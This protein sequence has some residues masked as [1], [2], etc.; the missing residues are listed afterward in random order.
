MPHFPTMTVEAIFDLVCS[1][2]LL[3]ITRVFIN[4][5]NQQVAVLVVV[6]LGGFKACFI[7]ADFFAGLPHLQSDVRWD[8][9]PKIETPRAE[10]RI[11]IHASISEC[12]AFHPPLSQIPSHPVLLIHFL[13]GAIN[14]YNQSVKTAFDRSAGGGIGQVVSISGRSPCK[15]LLE[16]YFTNS[17]NFGCK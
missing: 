4:G 11:S 14:R 1:V 5:W 2:G 15:S 3:G 9:P 13:R 17:K 8:E 12:S 7:Y 16:A 6:N 10:S